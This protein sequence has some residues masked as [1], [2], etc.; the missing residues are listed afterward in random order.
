MASIKRLRSVAQSTA[1]HSVSGLCY[2]HPHLG[3]KCKEMGYIEITMNFLGQEFSPDLEVI[4]RELELS[5]VALREFFEG[6]MNSENIEISEVAT[7]EVVFHF[8]LG[9][10]PSASTV[11]IVTVCGKTI[12]YCVDSAGKTIEIL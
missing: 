7:A 5:S 9:R 11:K 2:V 12:E 3:T 10:W 1:H 6:L 4:S 8:Q